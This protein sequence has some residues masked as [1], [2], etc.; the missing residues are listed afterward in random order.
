MAWLA[1]RH[2][3]GDLKPLG[4][5][6]CPLYD[7]V[8]LKPCT[9]TFPA[10][11]ASI[12]VALKNLPAPLSIFVLGS[13]RLSQLTRR[14]TFPMNVITSTNRWARLTHSINAFFV[15]LWVM[16]SYALNVMSGTARHGAKFSHWRRARYR[17][18]A[19][20]ALPIGLADFAPDMPR[21][22][23]DESSSTNSTYMAVISRFARFEGMGR[24][25]FS[26]PGCSASETATDNLNLVFE[27]LAALWA[28][29]F[30]KT[31]L[32]DR[33]LVNI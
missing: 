28:G 30:H 16:P 6:S 19:L 20:G 2:P 4:R 27:C 5:V 29:L 10:L 15:E 18:S 11:L 23:R 17:Y 24:R 8:R 1:Q 13:K 22:L 12:I 33:P 26:F 7:V 14:T 25:I 31:I 32:A 21:R 3:V 9:A